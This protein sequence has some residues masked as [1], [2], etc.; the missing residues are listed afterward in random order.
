MKAWLWLSGL[1]EPAARVC[2][3]LPCPAPGPEVGYPHLRV[4]IPERGTAFLGSGATS[5]WLCP[6]PSAVLSA[7][8][9]PSSLP[10]AG[11]NLCPHLSCFGANSS[12]FAWTLRACGPAK[13]TL[14]FISKQLQFIFY[15]MSSF[16]L[17]T[18]LYMAFPLK[19][20]P[21]LHAHIPPSI[22]CT[23]QT[24]H[25]LSVLAKPCLGTVVG[26]LVLGQPVWSH[27]GHRHFPPAGKRTFGLLAER[28]LTVS[29]KFI[30]NNCCTKGDGK[31]IFLSTTVSFPIF[32]KQKLNIS[33]I[34]KWTVH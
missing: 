2:G 3:P 16:P 4:S 31:T 11:W 13:C 26:L 27:P 32:F 24:P 10:S 22:L 29:C 23:C 5:C 7:G 18:T 19:K 28:K 33:A 20:S 6:W 9:C 21:P 12:I 17:W 34:K 15:V 25:A 8:G 30:S 14:F 1:W